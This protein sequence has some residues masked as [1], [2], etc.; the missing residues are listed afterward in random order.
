VK[1]IIIGLGV[2]ISIAIAAPLA[3]KVRQA[4]SGVCSRTG[5]TLTG[6]ELRGRVIADLVRLELDA[7]RHR[8]TE[9]VRGVARF[10]V[11]DD[12]TDD[13]IAKSVADLRKGRDAFAQ[14]F[15]FR[16]S[17]SGGHFSN[18]TKEPFVLLTYSVEKENV[19]VRRT[20]SAD[21]QRVD[22]SALIAAD[23]R[24]GVL[25][26]ARGFGS[27]YFQITT[28]HFSYD[29]C[30][31]PDAETSPVRQLVPIVY[32]EIGERGGVIASRNIARVA[33]VSNCGDILAYKDDSGFHRIKWTRGE[34]S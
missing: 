17:S 28:R 8:D 9:F 5:T 25:Q 15:S 7:V 19:S 4:D 11:V 33:P 32:R 6:E 24:P 12:I 10:R 26:K 34:D 20:A 23:Y 13:Q 3:W 30:L 16:E 1:A 27:H 29:C 22:L 2:A 31:P 21:I 14:E 18:L